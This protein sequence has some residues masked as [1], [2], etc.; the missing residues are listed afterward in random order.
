MTSVPRFAALIL[1]AV[2]LSSLGRTAGAQPA[3]GAAAGE[4]PPPADRVLLLPDNPGEDIGL[5]LGAT[6]DFALGRSLQQQGRTELALAY[7]NRAYRRAPGAEGIARAYAQSLL[8]AGFASDAARVYADLLRRQ[9]DDL[10]DRR[11]Y[12]VLLAQSGRPREALGEV[13]Q[14]RVRG[15]DDSEL[16]KLEADLLGQLDRIDEAIAV[17]RSGRPRRPEPARLRGHGMSRR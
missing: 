12:A 11:Q 7:L 4:L 15:E 2:C 5:P 1:C 14:L 8:E 9:P 10:E 16:I 17:C 13:R 6:R 3:G